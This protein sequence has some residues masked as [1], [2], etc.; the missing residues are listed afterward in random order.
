V[1]KKEFAAVYDDEIWSVYGFFA[2]RLPG[3]ADAE[4]LTQRTFER[5]LR[6]WRRFDPERA[7]VRVWLLTIARNLLIDHYRADVW[8]RQQ[9]IEEVAEGELGS[10][11]AQ[12]D[13]GIE[14]ELAEA[15]AEL[16][17]RDREVL[18]L[19]FGGDLT[20]PEIATITGLTLANVQQILSRSLRRLRARLE[21]GEL[22]RRADP[23]MRRTVG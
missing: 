20:G 1:P 16:V 6:A 7:P 9:A 15:L 13:L 22:D 18:A 11:L 12:P 19:R 21:G 3:A 8:G 2:Y 10:E 4:D 23:A 14:P 5:A 17:P